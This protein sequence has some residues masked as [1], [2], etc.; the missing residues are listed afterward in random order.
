MLI[1]IKLLQTDMTE[2]TPAT[3]PAPQSFAKQF[4]TNKRDEGKKLFSSSIQTNTEILSKQIRY[5]GKLS[6]WT[7][8][9]LQAQDRTLMA[10]YVFLTI[11]P[12]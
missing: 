2:L 6:R 9:H 7:D 5:D 8:P 11:L 1:S 10:G 4:L 12:I 3:F